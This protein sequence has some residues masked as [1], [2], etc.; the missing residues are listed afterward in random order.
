MMWKSLTEAIR[1]SE[2]WMILIKRIEILVAGIEAAASIFFILNHT[3]IK[4][5]I[6]KQDMCIYCILSGMCYNV[7]KN[8][9][10]E[11]YL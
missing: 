9:V 5:D 1:I 7:V 2:N 6:R 8:K 3:R 4:K 10:K 11:A